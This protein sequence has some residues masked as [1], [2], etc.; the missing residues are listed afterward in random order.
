[1]S[2][3]IVQSPSPAKPKSFKDNVHGYICIPRTIVKHIVDTELFQRLRD[4]QQ[5]GM[6]PV[7]P[8][9]SHDRFTHSLGTY[10]LGKYAF[11]SFRDN[12]TQVLKRDQVELGRVFTNQNDELT[13]SD[14]E[15]LAS[16]WWQKYELLFS[17]ACLLHDCAH[18]PF[19]HTFEFYLG[20]MREPVTDEWVNEID[21][22]RISAD[23]D[24]LTSE[25]YQILLLDK[26]MIQEYNSES[27]VSDYYISVSKASSDTA[28]GIISTA[29]GA[30]HE[31]L[32]AITVA[33]QFKQGIRIVCK[34]L[35]PT[36]AFFTTDTQDDDIEFMARC[37]L[38]LHYSSQM[39]ESNSIEL[40][41][42][43]SIISL[44][45]SS[46]A[47]VDNLDYIMRDAFNSGLESGAIDY[48]RFLDANTIAAVSVLTPV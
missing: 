12:A 4:I 3:P 24:T 34:E 18:T 37:I 22:P 10:H 35:Q 40:S 43:N 31:K 2:D 25:P 6:R 48:Q 30:Y 26:E 7:F 5:T 29:K 9:A 42:K 23:N 14:V 16:S 19:S 38:G 20:T 32:S 39:N 33:K 28:S 27:F 21:N 45:N 17:L 46:V 8:A 1:M 41:L 36:N 11:S 15:R 13:V 47:D 44:L